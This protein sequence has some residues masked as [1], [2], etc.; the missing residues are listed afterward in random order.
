MMAVRIEPAIGHP[1][2]LFHGDYMYPS[3]WQR[4]SLLSPDGERFLVVR[5]A[6]TSNRGQIRIVVNWFSELATRLAR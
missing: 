6:A 3:T 5:E 2:E 1:A 4:F